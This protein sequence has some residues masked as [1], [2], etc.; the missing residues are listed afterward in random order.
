MTDDPGAQPAE[1]SFPGQLEPALEVQRHAVAGTFTPEPWPPEIFGPAGPP[2]PESQPRNIL[3]VA[4][5][6]LA[7]RRAGGS[8]ILVDRLASGMLAR[9]HR[10]T[11][12]C[13]GPVA[14][15][16]YHVARNGGTYSQFL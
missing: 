1:M 14:E 5:R 7:N 6:D 3:F 10:V 9:G 16:P 13:G 12:L 8:E 2:G 4:W 15:R 11:L